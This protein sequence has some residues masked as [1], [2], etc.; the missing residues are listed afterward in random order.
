MN[1]SSRETVSWKCAAEI[2]CLPRVD[3]SCFLFQLISCLRLQLPNIVLK[4]K[5]RKNKR[6][7]GFHVK[8]Q[9]NYFRLMIKPNKTQS[10]SQASLRW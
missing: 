4:A 1:N 2:C 5:I 10:I 8:H 3:E 7:V 6:I 9:S